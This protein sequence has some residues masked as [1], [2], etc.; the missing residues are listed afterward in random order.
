[1]ADVV[2]LKGHQFFD[3]NGGPLNGGLLRTYDAGTSNART[4]Y[5]DDAEAIAWK[6]RDPI[7]QLERRMIGDKISNRAELDS[8][9][10]EARAAVAAA[11]EAARKLPQ[12]TAADLMEHLYA[13]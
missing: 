3:A 12:P 4:V 8:L 2:W 7:N 11:A 9:A 13:P 6:K 5:K 10:G 1:M